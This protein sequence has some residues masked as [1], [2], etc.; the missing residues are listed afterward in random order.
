MVKEKLIPQHKDRLGRT[1]AEGA[2]VA[3]P[4]TNILRIGII[5]R[6]MPKMVEVKTI[7]D[8]YCYRTNKYA[9]DLVLLDGPDTTFFIMANTN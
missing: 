4:D 3:F 8:Q 9:S 5:Q 1:L 7:G 2:C 6:F